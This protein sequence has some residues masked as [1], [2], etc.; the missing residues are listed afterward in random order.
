MTS[1]KLTFS[2]IFLLFATFSLNAQTGCPGCVID[3]PSMPI[4][5]LYLSPLP[6][7]EVNVPYDANASF[8]MPQTTTPINAIDP[9]I[10]AGLTISSYVLTGVTGMPLGLDY[11]P[12]AT[13]FNP[14]VDNDGCFR[15]CGTPLVPGT[16]TIFAMVDVSLGFITTGY[17]LELELIINGGGSSNYLY[18]MENATGCD[19]TLTTFTTSMPSNGVEGFTYYWNFGNGETSLLENPNPI[20]YDEP[21]EYPVSLEVNVDTVGILL[22]GVLVSSSTCGDLNFPPVS[23][24]EPD[25]YIVIKNPSGSIIY[26]S[27]E[28]QN[29]L[30]PYNFILPALPID[31][32]TYTIEIW[33]ADLEPVDADDLC[34]QFTFDT[35]YAGQQMS[36][37][38][39]IISIELEAPIFTFT[40]LDTVSVFAHPTA[41][42]LT[43]ASYS[44]GDTTALI[45]ASVVTANTFWYFDEQQVLTDSITIIATNNGNYTF[46]YID[47]NGCLSDVSEPAIIE[48]LE[49]P[50]QATWTNN[51]SN[52]LQMDDNLDL[53]ATYTLQWYYNGVEIPGA[54]YDT[55]CISNSGEY[56]LQVINTATGCISLFNAVAIFNPVLP[57]TSPSDD[58]LFNTLKLF[59]Q[60]TSSIVRLEGLPMGLNAKCVLTN[61]LG[62]VISHPDIKDLQLGWSVSDL[63]AGTYFLQIHTDQGKKTL[64]LLVVGR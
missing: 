32:G 59:P 54:T 44:C 58:K 15:F 4:D 5:T 20:F 34:G 28:Q 41:S 49:I 52:M 27:S 56:L 18:S 2:V 51:G 55:L 1:N 8:R 42:D 26:T 19:S 45:T 63:P 46:S 10:P 53:P 43:V 61:T 37:N 16:Y 17:V 30:L 35:T 25:L 39:T 31:T 22:N 33:D 13:S 60:P 6:E 50:V 7:G 64:P 57:C 12:S 62:Y 48:F 14:A 36:D 47:Q 3:I 38:S 24:P 9:T 11:T 40:A 21:G 29:A 23:I